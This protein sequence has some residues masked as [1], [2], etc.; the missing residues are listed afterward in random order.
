M[1]G[2]VLGVLVALAG[3]AA[4]QVTISRWQDLQ[5][6]IA[7]QTDKL[8]AHTSQIAA[9]EA[10]IAD[11]EAKNAVL[12][13]D[14]GLIIGRYD[15]LLRYLIIQACYANSKL[16]TWGAALAGLQP[17]PL[18]THECP[19]A[20]SRFYIPGYLSPSGPAIPPAN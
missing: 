15:M 17:F 11:L 14:V 6:Y 13:S 20:G 7:A 5:P 9:L 2:F 4:A 8:N 12:T 16:D 1:R 19:P 10:R 18:G 3:T